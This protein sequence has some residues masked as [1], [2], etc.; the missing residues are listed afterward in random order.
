MYCVCIQVV[1]DILSNV[2]DESNTPAFSATETVSALY[3]YH[4]SA[5]TSDFILHCIVYNVYVTMIGNSTSHAQ[6]FRMYYMYYN[7]HI[8]SRRREKDL[9]SFVSYITADYDKEHALILY[10]VVIGSTRIV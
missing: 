9:C 10:V 8:I 6:T 5:C 4:R 2:L 1:A 3:L 7:S